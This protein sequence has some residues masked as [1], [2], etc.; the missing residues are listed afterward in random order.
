LIA[1]FVC[2]IILYKFAK[3]HTTGK[4]MN[5]KQMLERLHRLYVEHGDVEVCIVD[6]Y[7]NRV[8][9]GDFLVESYLETTGKFTVDIAIGGL[10][11]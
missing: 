10:D 6:G 9:R 2:V 7:H 11:E 3:Q 5:I 1:L 4:K 8:Y